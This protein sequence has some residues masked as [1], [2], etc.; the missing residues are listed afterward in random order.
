MYIRINRRTG[1]FAFGSTP[2]ERTSRTTIV[3]N[4]TTAKQCSLRCQIA[5]LPQ[6][7]ARQYVLAT[8]RRKAYMTARKGCEG[9]MA[10]LSFRCA[11]LVRGVF[12]YHF[13]KNDV[14]QR[15]IFGESG[16]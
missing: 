11:F 1:T 14:G 4:S 3:L 5:I 13:L 15:N 6:L 8:V 2:I 16:N 12:L 10:L 9:G 7:P